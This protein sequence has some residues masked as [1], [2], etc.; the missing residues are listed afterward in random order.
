M[1]TDYEDEINADITLEEEPIPTDVPL[2]ASP[3]MDATGTTDVIQAS[4]EQ[5]AQNLPEDASTPTIDATVEAPD[6]PAETIPVPPNVNPQPAPANPAEGQPEGENEGEEPTFGDYAIDA[7]KGV[8]NGPIQA[9]FETADLVGSIVT[10]REV[11]TKAAAEELLG[12]DIGFDVETG[13]GRMTQSISSFITGFAAGGAILKTAKV[14]QGAG[15]MATAARGMAKSAYSSGTVYDGHEERLSN[16]VNEFDSLRN[17]VTEYLAADKDDDELEGRIKNVLEDLG[18]GV[19]AEF[20]LSLK[21]FKKATR[22]KTAAERD[23]IME[24]GA[25]ALEAQ[26][27]SQA[28]TPDAIDDV[29]RTTA[30]E[31]TPTPAVDTSNLD[32]SLP[33]NFP[34]AP[35][36]ITVQDVQRA[37]G[38]N[39]DEA[40]SPRTSTDEAGEAGAR[41]TPNPDNPQ[42]PQ[43]PATP[44]TDAGE[45]GVEG[46]AKPESVELTDE[47]TEGAKQLAREITEATD[48]AQSI[49]EFTEKLGGSTLFK[50][51]FAESQDGLNILIDAAENMQGKLLRDNK[52]TWEQLSARAMEKVPQYGGAFQKLMQDAAEGKVP[53]REASEASLILTGALDTMARRLSGIAH[54]I[55]DNE[56][57]MSP[58]DWL[59]FIYTKKNIDSLY[60]SVENLG[61][62]GGRFLNSRR[63]NGITIQKEIADKVTW[64]STPT[65]I[66]KADVDA[67]IAREGWTQETLRQAA[68]DVYHNADDSLSGVIRNMRERKP[69]TG[70]DMLQ[71]VRINGML[72]GPVTHAINLTTSAIKTLTSPAERFLGGTPIFNGSRQGNEAL[73]QEAMDIYA[74]FLHYAGESFAMAMK[75][76]R[77]GDAILD[78]M[79]ASRLDNFDTGIITRDNVSAWLGEGRF[80]RRLPDSVKDHIAG[81]ADIF[82]RIVRI[83]SRLMLGTDEFFKQLNYRSQVYASLRRE[84]RARGFNEDQIAAYVD[85][86]FKKAF[87]E[88]GGAVIPQGGA[89][90]NQFL[91]YSRQQ[92][93]TQD[94]GQGTLMYDAYRFINQHPSLKIVMPFVKTPSNII[95]DF[96]AH[97][98]WLRKVAA[99]SKAALAQGGEAAAIENAK[100]SVGVMTATMFISLGMSDMVTGSPPKDRKLREHLMNTGWRPY[101]FKIGDKY[102]EYKRVDPFA[103]MAGIGAD[104]ARAFKEIQNNPN[105]TGLIDIAWNTTSSLAF[106]IKDNVLNKT[107]MQGLSDFMNCFFS[108][109]NEEA[110]TTRLSKYIG[111]TAA[112]FV[113]FTS[114]LR[115]GR[116]QIDDSLKELRGMTDYMV[117]ALP[118]F[119]ESLPTRYNWV[120]GT[121]VHNTGIV[122]DDKRDAVFNELYRIATGIQTAPIKQLNGI[123]LSAEQYSRLC[124]LHGTVTINGRTLYEA[125]ENLFDS[126]Q[127]DINRDR[128]YDPPEMA[129]SPRSRMVRRI[130]GTYR[131]RAQQELLDEYPDLAEEIRMAKYRTKMTRSGAMTRENEVEMMQQIA[132]Y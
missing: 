123:D 64:Y 73:R 72:S 106:A 7:L 80:R 13:A 48:R 3:L 69:I 90:A 118:G 5:D 41:E 115:F 29:T 79:G 75:A 91:R 119:S 132:L 40:P 43:T 46:A 71:E 97:T 85:A 93:W 96:A 113:P 81:F 126:P 87:D 116:Y 125:L 52:E 65:N 51:V 108:A 15:K 26:R 62:Y 98:P 61:T 24:E 74:G 31:A 83:P 120:D 21:Y 42:T 10:G 76:L 32:F 49:E 121:P 57:A 66:S 2:Y 33:R 25:D 60:T 37:L 100:V 18:V 89:E 9:A 20:L 131:K 122:N 53:L 17:P 101:S 54:K 86:N 35:E 22:A 84:G 47:V 56:A 58:R 19:A 130:I 8:A 99:E 1:P 11:D 104:I 14:L 105:D 34:T 55:I 92:T 68:N 4:L 12:T 36:R 45:A 112:S 109:D 38:R 110:V 88:F 6:S 94:L 59:E 30:G 129:E 50:K 70:F 78:T 111:N 114:L 103:M 16:L 102:I 39:V 128:L 67:I 63:M 95:R 28:Q 23:A 107:Y 117:N 44:R 82:G 124:E 127:Y 77:G 27:A